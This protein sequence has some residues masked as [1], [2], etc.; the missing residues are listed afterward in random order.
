MSDGNFILNYVQ[1]CAS[2][3]LAMTECGPMWQMAVIALL[4]V[5]AV[6]ALLFLRLRAGAAPRE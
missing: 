3:K 1:V 5:L 6:A 2:G 4:L